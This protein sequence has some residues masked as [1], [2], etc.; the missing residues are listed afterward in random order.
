MR[1]CDNPFCTTLVCMMGEGEVSLERDTSQERCTV[2]LTW[3]RDD[4][5]KISVLA[6]N[7]HDAIAEACEIVLG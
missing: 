4:G 7:L 5:R 3:D 1:T 6:A 2:R